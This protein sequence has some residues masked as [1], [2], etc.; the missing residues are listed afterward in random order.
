M[1]KPN[2][3]DS[4]SEKVILRPMKASDLNTVVLLEQMIFTDAWPKSAFVDYLSNDPGIGLIIAE[5]QGMTTGYASYV[6][7]TG[8]AHLTNIAVVP[9]YRGKS[10]AKLLINRILEIAINAGCE[11]IYL[12]VR[13]SNSVAIELYKKFGFNELYLKAGYYQSPVEDAIVMVKTLREEKLEN[14]LV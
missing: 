2:K 11:Y 7:A 1:V 14:G 10:I 6:I 3:K 9:E 5:S 12:D 13:Q 4:I 8:E